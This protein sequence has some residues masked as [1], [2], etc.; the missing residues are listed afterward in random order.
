MN[1]YRILGLI[2]LIGA[3]VAC[4]PQPTPS[5]LLDLAATRLAATTPTPATT[6]TAFPTRPPYPPGTL[7]DYTAQTGDTLPALAA[8]FNTTEAEIRSANPILPERVTTLPPG[9]PMK[10]PIYYRPLWGSAY[11]ILPDSLFING[12]AQQGFDVVAFVDAQPGWFKSYTAYLGG[13]NRRGGEIIA[14]IAKNFSLSPRLLLALLEY[15]TGALTQPEMPSDL[16]PY[17][18]G[19]ADRNYPGLGQQLT[20]AANTL[21]NG[22]YAWRSGHL[23]SIELP[24]G[25]EETIDPWQNAASAA[26]HYYFSRMLSGAAYD[27]AIGPDG[28]AAT[29]RALF[30]DPWQDVQP[31][32][33][34]SLEQPALRFPFTP[35]KR[36]SF[37]GGPH[38]AWGSGEPLAALDFA[39]PAVVGGC[40]PSEEW[41]TAV[42]DGVIA[43]VDTASVVLDLDGDGD[44][45]TG[46]TIYYLHLAQASLPA[47]GTVLK[48][49]DPIGVPSC[50]GGTA[51][52]T[53]VHIAR[54]YNGEWIPAD[55][56]LAFNLEGWVAVNGAA[57]YEGYLV[58][59]GQR[60]RACLCS[61]YASQVESRP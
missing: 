56:P 13:Q 31:H 61:D 4:A 48:A 46:W 40:Q 59:R 23:I 57:P 9:L 3:V 12:P 25:R 8:R 19:Y 32:L 44:E 22:Y 18:L 17:P 35:G 36:W 39:P 15:H 11:Q 2:L 50:E 14:H 26:L 42:A 10:I 34:G 51:T 52:G 49:G 60:I 43:R 55:G 6:A 5:P 27:R 37:T 45:R 58:Q 30:G 24:D 47:V 7:V 38:T 41:A 20:W 1:R 33:P 28:L 29:Y 54:R 53:H 16:G 21:N